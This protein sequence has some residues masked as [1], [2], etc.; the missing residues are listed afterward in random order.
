MTWE[1]PA[2]F[3]AMGGHAFYV[4]GS[5]GACLLLMVVEP[6]AAGRRRKT[7]LGSLRRERIAE[8]LDNQ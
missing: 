5:F 4:W 7:I 8:Q 6:F 1:S 3:F 2:A